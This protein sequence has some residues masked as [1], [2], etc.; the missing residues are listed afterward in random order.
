MAILS[1]RRFLQACGAG[2]SAASALTSGCAPFITPDAAQ[3]SGPSLSCAEPTQRETFDYI[4]VGSGAG[5]GPLA[6]NLALAGF[7]V[8]LLEAGGEEENYDYQVP[9]FHA[10]AS[11]D[12]RFAWNFFVR[13]YEDDVQQRRDEKF[14]PARDGVL[15][16]RCATL[17]GCTAHNA[18][19]LIYPHNSD[20]D[21]IAE[22]TGDPSWTA[23]RMRRYF[24]RLERCEYVAA[25]ETAS[26]HGFEGWLPT[27]VA[28]PTLMFRDEF[29]AILALAYMYV[30][31]FFA[32]LTAHVTAFFVPFL[33]A[34]VAAGAPPYFAALTFA[35]FSSL[36]ASSSVQTTMICLRRS[37]FDH[38]DFMAITSASRPHSGLSPPPTAFRPR[39]KAEP[40]SSRRPPIR[41]HSTESSS[42][43]VSPRASSSR[44]S[45]RSST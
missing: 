27:N 16:P 18:M 22:V 13:H 14:L 24:E 17:G 30:H 29:L 4:V 2:V 10:R 43:T 11:E 9:A 26:R 36:C 7:H 37:P 12:E 1:R 45:R 44:S 42:P 38:T 35:F 19:I 41:W 23:E 8:L 21:H 40:S 25:S 20:W 15:Y 32:S 28:D 31:Y 3:R 6:A 39:T 33:I 5:G 34:A